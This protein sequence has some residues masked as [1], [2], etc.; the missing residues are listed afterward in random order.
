[1][2]SEME[3][4]RHSLLTWALALIIALFA[5]SLYLRTLQPTLGGMFNSE[6]YQQAA[7]AL[8][9]AHSTGYP[10]YLILG[11]IFITLVPIG[12]AA[13]RMNLFSAFWA[14]GAAIL[15]YFIVL[16]LTQNHAAGVLSACLF[17]SNEAVWRYAS[18]AEV[19]T[20]TAFLA[21]AV[22]L[23]LLLWRRG[24][25]PLEFSAV[26]YGLALAH[27]RTSIFYAPGIVLFVL[28]AQRDILRDKLRLARLIGLTLLPLLI[29][30]YVPLRAQTAPDYVATPQQLFNYIVGL[31]TVQ[32]SESSYPIS[33]WHIHADL[34]LRQYLWAW[35]AG[36]GIPIA[37]IGFA[38]LPRS[39]LPNVNNAAR[40][41][42]LGPFLFLTLF[43]IPPRAPD[44]DR[45]LLL[46]VMVLAIG[47]G[48]GTVR[49]FQFLRALAPNP[50]VRRAAQA[51]LCLLLF[52]LVGRAVYLNLPNVDYSRNDAVYRV[53]RE[54]LELPIEPGAVVIGN[55]S[56][57]NALLYMQRVEGR[58]TD[59]KIVSTFPSQERVAEWVEQNANAKAIYLAPGTPGAGET[60][61]YFALGPLLRVTK[62]PT[63]RALE[64]PNEVSIP[65]EHLTLV[66]FGLNA[67]LAPGTSQSAV[68]IEPGES[69]R[70]LLGWQV[71]Q[72]PQADYQVWLRLLDSTGRA[73]WQG[74][75]N[76]LRG[77]YPTTRWQAKSY[78]ADSQLV[79]IPPGTPPGQYRIEVALF[80]GPE[81]HVSK[82]MALLDGVQ[83]MRSQVPLG[84]QVFVQQRTNISISPFELLGYSGGKN[85]EK[86][87]STLN[88]G[89]GWRAIEKPT[90]DYML[91]FTL[92]DP[93]GTPRAPTTVPLL[94]EFPTSRWQTNDAFKAY[95]ALDI[96][97]DAAQGKWQVRLA[98]LDSAGHA[99]PV[100]SRQ[101][102]LSL[103]PFEVHP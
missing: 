102:E 40:L 5:G 4:R 90:T 8:G 94:Q 7:Y 95:Y 54:I 39:S 70:L 1:M 20:L 67:S 42:L 33:E 98:I 44:I 52:L 49:L 16:Q 37:F 63:L 36:I 66:G 64:L 13:F 73:L 69:V 55:W 86:P 82:E 14:A 91:R 24:R 93:N 77:T 9:L 26:L 18:V 6:E 65:F 28:L 3:L 87:G 56:E 48:L 32:N 71:D 45:Y 12:N 101:D 83:V 96:P 92:M 99:L 43:S 35:F 100:N 38:G 62:R 30:L 47:V 19:D 25:A 57:S 80:N 79:Y 34:I 2:T 89:I 68:Q 22:F 50:F 27:H 97:E 23:T 88:I 76:P 75:E 51:I 72:V 85:A 61:H 31:P 46:P 29:Y 74:L 10:L 59:L 81:Q 53:W 17:A 60:Y 15:I 84:D 78:V 103:F 21:G 11:K 58:R 41:L